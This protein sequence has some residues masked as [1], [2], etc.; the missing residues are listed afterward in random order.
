MVNRL[1]VVVM[2]GLACLSAQAAFPLAKNGQPAARIVIAADAHPAVAYAAE[3]LQRW[4]EAI[5]GA[6]LPI[7]TG[8]G[9]AGP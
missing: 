3:E 7:D 4:V 5:S 8:A 6:R 9:G 2:A 1:A